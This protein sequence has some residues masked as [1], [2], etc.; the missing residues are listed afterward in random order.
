MKINPRKTKGNLK[1]AIE[2]AIPTSWLD[3]IMHRSK[4]S[5]KWTVK[6]EE[7]FSSDLS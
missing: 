5:M 2:A 1:K 4:I 7:K 3:R 6:P